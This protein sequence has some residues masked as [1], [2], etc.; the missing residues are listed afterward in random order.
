[1]THRNSLAAYDFVATGRELWRM[2]ALEV[3]NRGGTT[4]DMCA[5]AIGKT[6]LYTRPLVCE[7][8]Q[9]GYIYDTGLNRRNKDSGKMASVWAVT[10]LGAN[11]LRSQRKD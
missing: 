9:L 7:M 10:E 5:E 4:A 8:A 3:F 1:M 6:V 11:I 2:K